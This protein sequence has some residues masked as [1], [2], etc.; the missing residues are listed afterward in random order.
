VTQ[1]ATRR[2]LPLGLPGHIITPSES[3]GREPESLCMPYVLQELT[4]TLAGAPDPLVADG[5]FTISIP[6]PWGAV[7][8]KAE[9]KTGDTLAV[10]A[11]KLQASWVAVAG[12]LYTASTPALVTTVQAKS[13]DLNIAPGAF[14]I[15]APAGY[16]ITP[17]Q[18][19][20]AAAPN[21]RMGVFC[22][23]GS[24]TP[25]GAVIGT[26]YQ[27][28]TAALLTVDT[29]IEQ[30]R[31][32]VAREVNST[33][34]SPVFLDGI[35]PDQ[36]PPAHYFPVLNRGEIFTVVDP[37]SPAGAFVV[38]ASTPI[39]VVRASGAYSIVGAV[40]SAAD[41][42][43]TLRIDNAPTGNILAR[44]TVGEFTYSLG[45]Y[46]VRLVGLKVNVTN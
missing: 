5:D 24:L 42:L 31:G 37:A 38:G 14:T 27:G 25:V 44:V 15:A 17:A 20:A 3:P 33:E 43:N 9:G 39:Y 36:Y 2:H 8:V 41:G 16:T 19:V 7:V 40:A 29:P 18:T 11:A 1:Y 10:I 12:N 46:T 28:R 6:A 23:Y 4:F 13:F 21:I 22:K 45:S 30:I 26:P 32:V 34:L 35:N